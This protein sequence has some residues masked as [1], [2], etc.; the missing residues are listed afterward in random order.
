MSRESGEG[1]GMGIKPRSLVQISLFSLMKESYVTVGSNIW[2]RTW[3]LPSLTV[4]SMQE[5]TMTAS[6]GHQPPAS[7]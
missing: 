5:T 1:Q 7:V 4:F 6:L 3:G 2:K